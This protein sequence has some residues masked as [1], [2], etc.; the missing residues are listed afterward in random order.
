MA[1][2][3][4]WFAR[5]AGVLKKV[6]AV[7]LN[8]ST[9]VDAPLKRCLTA[10][11]AFDHSDKATSTAIYEASHVDRPPQARLAFQS[12]PHTPSLKIMRTIIVKTTTVWYISLPLYNVM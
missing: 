10:A 11:D 8:P 7:L 1:V 4:G 3:G 5:D 2:A 12:V 6:G 9:K